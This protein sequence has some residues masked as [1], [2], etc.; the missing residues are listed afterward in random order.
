MFGLGVD[1]ISGGVKYGGV[2]VCVRSR[3]VFVPDIYWVSMIFHCITVC[4]D[5]DRVCVCVRS[6]IGFVPD[7]CWFR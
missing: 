2:F 3:I 6:R 5:Y 1:C 7:K 4:V